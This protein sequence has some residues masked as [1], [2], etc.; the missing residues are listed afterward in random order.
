[1]RSLESLTFGYEAL[2][3]RYGIEIVHDVAVGIDPV[4]RRVR[5]AGGTS[6]DYD[7]L[8]VSPG[9]AFDVASTPGFDE[10]VGVDAWRDGAQTRL[11]RAQLTAMKDGGV[12]LIVAPPD[13][14]RC[15]QGPYE[16][17]SL[18]AY[19]LKQ[20]KPRSKVLI[21]D[22]K[23]SFVGQDLFL[24]GWTRHYPGMI[25]WAP[26]RST[27]QIHAVNAASVTTTSG[28]FKADIVNVIPAQVAGDIARASGLVDPSRWCPVDPLTFESKLQPSIHVIGDSAAAGD[29]PKSAFAAASQAKACA[30]AIAAAMTGAQPVP[31]LLFNAC[32]THLA[33]DDAIIVAERF[34][35]RRGVIEIVDR[36]ASEVGE[37]KETRRRN[38]QRAGGWYDAF[39]QDV[40]A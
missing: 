18:A 37:S 9:I 15:P 29:M 35:P 14:S 38:V 34:E 31:A 32:F 27:G 2:T 30:F 12:V 19:F 13:P 28:T 4:R 6:L 10:A 39:T 33:G 24:D 8:V 1:M 17:A 21:L 20:F 3:A 40:F 22:A 36:S 16:R 7:R 5:L 11:L 25:E 26:A 23:E